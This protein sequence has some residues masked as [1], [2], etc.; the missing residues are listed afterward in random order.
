MTPDP[1]RDNN[2]MLMHEVWDPQDENDRVGLIEDGDLDN[3]ELFDA[4]K[5]GFSMVK[6]MCTCLDIVFYGRN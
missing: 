6:G 5:F 1:C 3:L 2:P 4:P